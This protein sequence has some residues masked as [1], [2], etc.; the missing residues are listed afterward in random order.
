MDDL[1]VGHTPLNKFYSAIMNT[2]NV[3]C[4]ANSINITKYYSNTDITISPSFLLSRRTVV[5]NYYDK[6]S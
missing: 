5:T 2:N 4:N 3:I 6:Y 1:F